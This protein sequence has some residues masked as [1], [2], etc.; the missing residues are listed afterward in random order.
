[1][2]FTIGVPKE[3]VKGENRVSIVPETARRFKSIGADICIER[4]AGAGSYFPDEEFGADQI[5]TDAAGVYARSQVVFRVQ[6]PSH[7]EI[8]EMLPGTV[9]VGFLRPFEDPERA[10]LFCEKNITS[11]A[12]ELVPRIPRAQA[13]DALSSQ[14]TVAGYLCAIIAARNCPKFF[15]MITFAAG[16]L[17]PARVLVIGVGVA[18]LQAIATAH[19]LGAIVEA[20]DVRPETREQAESVGAR[21]IDTGVTAAGSGGYARELTSEEKKLQNERLAN[22]ISRVDVLIT[23]AALPGKKSPLIVTGEMVASM[24]PGAVIVDMA[25]EGGGNVAGT[26]PGETVVTGGV[27]ILGPLNLPSLMPAHASEMF[28]K[29]LFNFLAPQVK[30]GELDMDWDDEIIAGSAFT[31]G[32]QIRNEGVRNALGL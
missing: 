15:P 6:A 8:G 29:N 3:T 20:Y 17:R 24:K 9:V 1:M 18:G 5:V 12:L 13:M 26:R 2:A 30:N 16:T 23:T 27:T 25:A 32:G 31:H 11:F 4:G 10:R 28:S 7:N 14:A 22:A 21:F 19:R